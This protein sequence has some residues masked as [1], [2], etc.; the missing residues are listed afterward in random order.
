MHWCYPNPPSGSQC[1]CWEAGDHHMENWKRMI[2]SRS[3]QTPTLHFFPATTPNIFWPAK[4]FT[5]GSLVSCQP[6]SEYAWRGLFL[7]SLCYGKTALRCDYHFQT[8]LLCRLPKTGFQNGISHECRQAMQ[9]NW[10][11]F[12]TSYFCASIWDCCFQYKKD[13]FLLKHVEAK[14]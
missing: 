2:I 5:A 13:A 12:L 14:Q 6:S 4:F 8:Y 9:V 1:K 7:G 3:K 11:I 10:N